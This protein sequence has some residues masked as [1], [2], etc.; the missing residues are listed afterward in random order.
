MK[1]YIY[2]L[3]FRQYF[4]PVPTNF[5]HHIEGYRPIRRAFLFPAYKHG[6]RPESDAG[7]IYL[8]VAKEIRLD[9]GVYGVKEP[10]PD[11]AKLVADTLKEPLYRFVPLPEYQGI[12]PEKEGETLDMMTELK[13]FA[14]E[15][16]KPQL[17]L[18]C[19][20]PKETFCE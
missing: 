14:N 2:Q 6:D 1:D 11:K 9:R 7:F 13:V 18:T 8:N 12:L 15:R 19:E 5:T 4:F 16:L 10:D 3:G 20:K 17:P